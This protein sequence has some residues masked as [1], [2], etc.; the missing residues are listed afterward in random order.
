MRN[1]TSVFSGLPAA[2]PG[3][4]LSV[5][6]CLMEAGVR[7][8]ARL[9]G[10]HMAFQAFSPW[11]PLSLS[12]NSVAEDCRIFLSDSGGLWDVGF[13]PLSYTLLRGMM[14]TQRGRRPEVTLA[15]LLLATAGCL[16]DLSECCPSLFSACFSEEHFA[17]SRHVKWKRCPSSHNP[18]QSPS[19]SRISKNTAFPL[20]FRDTLDNTR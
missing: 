16:A 8:H 3:R 4:T 17:P 10:H 2:Q 5:P 14:T 9:C 12:L 20:A 11:P 6:A 1:G 7:G 15:C 13:G 19:S 18:F